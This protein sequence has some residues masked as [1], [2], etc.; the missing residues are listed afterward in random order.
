MGAGQHSRTIA[1]L[2]NSKYLFMV[3]RFKPVNRAIFI[4]SISRAKYFKICLN[5]AVEIR[6]R[7]KIGFCRVMT[8]F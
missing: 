4:A 7:F 1:F 6:E 8:A 2:I 3:F 5:L